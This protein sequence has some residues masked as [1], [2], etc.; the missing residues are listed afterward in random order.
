LYIDSE[1]VRDVEIDDLK[2]E[3]ALEKEKSGK[4]QHSLDEANLL[5]KTNK[6]EIKEKDVT[7][8]K[9]QAK[10]DDYLDQI[11]TLKD[12]LAELDKELNLKILDVQKYVFNS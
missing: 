4:L 9:I 10:I 12:K 8:A 3:L 2:A 7:I 1:A 6:T 5:L 11:S